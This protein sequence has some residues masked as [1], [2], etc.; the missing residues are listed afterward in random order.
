MLFVP[1]QRVDSGVPK[2]LSNLQRS[3][4]IIS[5]EV[6]V[7]ARSKELRCDGCVPSWNELCRDGLIATRGSKVER[8]APILQR[9]DAI[10]RLEVDVT[11][12]SKELLRDGGLP[13]IGREVERCEPVDLQKVDVIAS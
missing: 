3:S 6:D 7:T 2:A 1:Y 11:A 5:L 9:S 10:R 12:R 13:I 4:A 8:R